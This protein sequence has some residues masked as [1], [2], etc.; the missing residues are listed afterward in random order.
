MSISK[1]IFLAIL[2]M[3]SYNRD[4]GAGINLTGNAIGNATIGTN[5]G[6]IKDANGN[7]LDEAASFFAQAYT[8]NEGKSYTNADGT[9]GLTSGQ[10]VISYRGTDAPGTDAF[11][12]WSLGAGYT[13]AS[14]AGLARSFYE[15]V[16]NAGSAVPRSVFD[17]PPLGFVLTG[18]SLGG[19]LAGY[20][21]T[22]Q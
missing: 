20:V 3:D 15:S 22:N 4:Y 9:T 13:A 8:I 5:S 14:Q 2:A 21:G 19:G 17:V 7:R 10:T 11:T 16:I 6:A 1:D 12:G 18:H